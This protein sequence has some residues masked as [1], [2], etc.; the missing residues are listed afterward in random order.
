MSDLSINPSTTCL[1]SKEYLRDSKKKKKPSYK[2]FSSKMIVIY[3]SYLSLPFFFINT[4]IVSYDKV[5]NRF[6]CFLKEGKAK[7]QRWESFSI[8]SIL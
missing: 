3:Y 5:I 7:P 4:V 1:S 8:L 2:G 6:V